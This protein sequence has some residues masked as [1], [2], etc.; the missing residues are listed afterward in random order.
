[1]MAIHSSPHRQLYSRSSGWSKKLNLSKVH[2]LFHSAGCSRQAN[3][4][5]WPVI[6]LKT[7]EPSF[8][9]EIKSLL[10]SR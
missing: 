2:K 5:L 6:R 3:Q 8:P 10:G 9:K 4:Q 7:Q 1:M